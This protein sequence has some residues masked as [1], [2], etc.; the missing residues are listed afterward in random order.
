MKENERIVKDAKGVKGKRDVCSHTEPL[1]S[2]L[3]PDSSVH[4][5]S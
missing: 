4:G 3:R 5:R 1:H 2:E